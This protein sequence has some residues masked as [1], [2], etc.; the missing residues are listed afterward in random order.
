MISP[1]RQ[2]QLFDKYAPDPSEEQK[3]KIRQKQ[4]K[5]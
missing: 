5:T 3:D 2:Q 1:T 4:S